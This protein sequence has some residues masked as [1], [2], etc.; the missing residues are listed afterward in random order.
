[1]MLSITS[2][3]SKFYRILKA[4]AYGFIQDDC[5]T[6]A[7]T[8][9]FYTLQSIV[10]FLAAILAIAKGFG[11]DEYLEKL[12]TTTFYDQREVLNYA[13]EV[14]YSM[15][16][17]IQSGE[18]VGVGVVFLIWTNLNLVGYIELA[19]NEIWKVKKPRTMFQKLRD[20]SAMLLF[21]P[22]IFVVS[23]S[24]TLFFKAFLLGL[25]SYPFYEPIHFVMYNFFRLLP[26]FLAYGLFTLFYLV[27]PNTK[28]RFWPRLIAALLAGSLF[29]LWQTIFINF[30][31][32]IFSY[33]V[34]YGAFAL[35]P[36]FFVWLQFSWLIA[37]AGA[38]VAAHIENDFH[39]EDQTGQI[40]TERIGKRQIAL[41]VLGDCL[42]AFYNGNSPPSDRE[43]AQREKI[44]LE[45]V[46]K[47]LHLLEQDGILL[48]LNTDKGIVYHP[49][50]DPSRYRLKK[51]C[52]IADRGDDPE[53]EVAA[54]DSLKKINKLLKH[55]DLEVENSESNI[56]LNHLFTTD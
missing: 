3:F 52:D 49:L 6:K 26:I 36:L 28:I 21:F 50:Y 40:E 24:L 5:Y 39:F 27:I 45:Q 13:I 30:Q 46:Q 32:Q 12:I 44:P 56:K 4:A 20:F 11:F 22:I 29:L 16:K 7:S 31:I 9:T 37:L 41:L 14:A 15:L 33:N 48:S 8:L 23:S 42:R 19:L 35:I 1:M 47:M 17:Y 38:E 34:V 53:L 2:P 18:V 43:I 54:T 25:N 55:M 51:V 10:P